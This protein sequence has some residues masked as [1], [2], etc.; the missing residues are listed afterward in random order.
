MQQQ[1]RPD[2]GR[3]YTLLALKIA[4]SIIL[5]VV[6]FRNVDM[7]Q[8]WAS[9][10]AAS[11]AWLTA[12]LAIYTVN[13]LVSAWRWHLLLHA[14][15]VPITRFK[16][17]GSFL[18]AAFFNNFLPSNIGGDVIRITDTAGPAR[19]KTL[20][21]MIVFMD[22]ALGLMGLVL[23][24]ALGATM[25]SAGASPVSSM[26]LWGALVVGAAFGGPAV[27]A[28]EAFARLLKPLTLIHQE[29][30]A[31][32]IVTLE[33]TLARFRD[34]FAAIVMTFAGAVAVQALLVVFYLAVARALAIPIGLWDLAVIVPV[35][36]VVQMVP[37]SVNGFGVR[38]A[39][40][41]LYF[42]RI[43]LPVESAILLS[44]IAQVLQMLFSLTGAAVYVG[45]SA[46]RT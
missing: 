10:R 32:R 15:H 23:V 37:V 7:E 43:G 26:W 34:A 24:A 6:L 9:A 44:L 27:L 3:R 13:V 46:R 42:K 5:L 30:V 19:S 45:R 29:W 11:P 1:T 31:A 28:P 4:V 20:A 21:A 38:E 16:V 17:L 22:R 12:A 36:F 41:G 2:S 33:N 25:A 14:Q 8:V 40:F 18:V 39:T 35:S